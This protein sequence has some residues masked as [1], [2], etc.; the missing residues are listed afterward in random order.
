MLTRAYSSP[1]E[2][3]RHPQSLRCQSHSCHRPC[4]ALL[5]HLGPPQPLVVALAH[6]QAYQQTSAAPDDA[7]APAATPPGSA[8]AAAQ[9]PPSTGPGPSR[10]SSVR[11]MFAGRGSSRALVA[12]GASVRGMAG[13]ARRDSQQEP[14]GALGEV[15]TEPLGVVL[16]QEVQLFNHQLEVLVSGRRSSV[17]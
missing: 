6:K 7:V 3:L 17:A 14:T 5:P 11:D 12:R 13:S 10:R 1:T 15:K 2:P 16:L 8:R 9:P 4:Q